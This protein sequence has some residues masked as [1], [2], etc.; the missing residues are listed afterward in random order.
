MGQFGEWDCGLRMREET[1]VQSTGQARKAQCAMLHT[2]LAPQTRSTATA[3][4]VAQGGKQNG[5]SENATRSQ[6]KRTDA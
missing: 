1:R 2:W 3:L 4:A 5:A 6:S